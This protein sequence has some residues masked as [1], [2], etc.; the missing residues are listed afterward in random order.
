MLTQG[1]WV[2]AFA[3]SLVVAS[4]TWAS[5]MD[6]TQTVI[7]GV[8]MPYEWIKKTEFASVAIRVIKEVP[9]T[10]KECCET[11][12]L[13]TDY[14]VADTGKGKALV[15]LNMVGKEVEVKGRVVGDGAKRT[16]FVS[17][18]KLMEADEKADKK[19]WLA[20]QGR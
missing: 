13:I 11:R 7:R 19:K 18:Y 17:E 15:D 12:L 8:V 2:A 9:D 1:R 5:S 16:L 3:L 14:V 20:V 6:S 4:D 10:T